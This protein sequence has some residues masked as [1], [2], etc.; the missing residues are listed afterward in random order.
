MI[1]QDLF[2]KRLLPDCPKWLP[3]NTQFVCLTGSVSYGVSSD[4]SDM[5]LVGWAIPRKEQVFPHL[6]GYVHGLGK[7]FESYTHYR[8]DHI[9]DQT[10]MRGKGREYDLCIYSIVR[11]FHFLYNGNANLIDTLYV[12]QQDILHS[13]KIADLVRTEREIFIS[14]AFFK[15]IKSYAYSQLHKMRSKNPIGKRKKLREEFGFDRKF[16]ENIVRLMSQLEQLMIDGHLELKEKSRREHLKAIRNGEVS[17]EDIIKWASQKELELEKLYNNSNI[18][19]TP[20][21]DEVKQLLLHC[22][23]SHYGT[24]ENCVVD[25]NKAIVALRQIDNIISKNRDLL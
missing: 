20:N 12:D 8:R 10:A 3:D 2:N 14:K 24:I 17:E 21:M 7:P 4:T 9:F 22:L 1:V 11:Y 25:P 6:K 16:G 5:D 18:R 15:Q 19:N 13:T 23:E